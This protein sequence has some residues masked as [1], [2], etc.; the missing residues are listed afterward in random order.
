VHAVR[1]PPLLLLAASLGAAACSGPEAPDADVC[2]DYVHR[3]CLPPRCARVDAE[4]NVAAT[5]EA[6]LLQRTG[7]GNPA[8]AFTVPTRERFLSCRAPLL[9]QGDGRE[10]HPAC[11]DVSESFD[12]CADVVSF[13]N[14]VA[15]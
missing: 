13:L 6:V 5:C 3:I 15:P 2:A 4:L 12:R 10:Q 1:P 9:R 8:F 14:G 7:C 11:E